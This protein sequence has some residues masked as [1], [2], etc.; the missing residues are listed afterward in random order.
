MNNMNGNPHYSVSTVRLREMPRRGRDQFGF[1]ADS[2][3]QATLALAYEQRT[4]NL[5]ASCSL[6]VNLIAQG[7]ELEDGGREKLAGLNAT[8]EVRLGLNGDAS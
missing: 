2:L 1:F 6:A 5:L 7:G 3:T 8:I 4:A